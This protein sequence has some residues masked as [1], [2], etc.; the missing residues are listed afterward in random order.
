[1]TNYSSCEEKLTSSECLYCRA[2]AFMRLQSPGI[3]YLQRSAIERHETCVDDNTVGTYRGHLLLYGTCPQDLFLP[4]VLTGHGRSVFRA[5]LTFVGP[6]STTA[7]LLN[8]FGAAIH[9][10]LPP[11]P[12]LDSSSG[13]VRRSRQ[14]GRDSNVF[15]GYLRVSSTRSR[16]EARYT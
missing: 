9:D 6:L 3:R 8:I 11:L 13:L 5:K 12:P 10:N 1:M 16:K 7:K 15:L 4:T 2:S 14:L